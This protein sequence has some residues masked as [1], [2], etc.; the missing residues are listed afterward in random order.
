[1]Q[2]LLTVEKDLMFLGRETRPIHRTLA[3]TTNPFIPGISGEEDKS[4]A[5]L[6]SLDIKPRNGEKWRAL[7]DLSDEEKKRLCSALADYLL[8]KGLRYEVT[9]LIGHVYILNQRRTLDSA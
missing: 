5:F 3:S 6:A 2:G 1:M 7:R 9:N 4:L 8:S